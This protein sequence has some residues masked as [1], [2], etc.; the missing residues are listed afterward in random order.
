MSIKKAKDRGEKQSLKLSDAIFLNLLSHTGFLIKDLSSKLLLVSIWIRF[1]FT[2]SD[3]LLFWHVQQHR[4]GW[5]P[6]SPSVYLPCLP[7]AFHLTPLLHMLSIWLLPKH[8]WLLSANNRIPN[9]KYSVTRINYKQKKNK[10]GGGEGEKKLKEG[11]KELEVFLGRWSHL[12]D[13]HEPDKEQDK[14]TEEKSLNYS[15]QDSELCILDNRFKIL[16]FYGSL[17]SHPT[18]PCTV[19]FSKAESKPNSFVGVWQLDAEPFQIYF[20]H[21]H[22]LK[23][24]VSCQIAA[25]ALSSALPH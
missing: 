12:S 23:V 21:P 24:G 16:L 8:P 1:L 10:R 13:C 2:F 7:P 20:V 14:S 9:I 15:L 4:E 19:L 17:W 22:S 18:L 25:A 3:W 11:S 6:V 5:G